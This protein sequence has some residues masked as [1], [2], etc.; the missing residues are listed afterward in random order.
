MGREAVADSPFDQEMQDW[1]AR[2]IPAMVKVHDAVHKICEEGRYEQ[3][4]PITCPMCGKES[5]RYSCAW[6]YNKHVH[7]NCGH[8]DFGFME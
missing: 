4:P 5:N 3:R 8:C 6:D 2:A 1:M 7:F